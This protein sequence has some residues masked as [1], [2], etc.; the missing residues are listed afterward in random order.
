MRGAPGSDG[1]AP[2]HPVRAR[3][4]RGGRVG[5]AGLKM[6]AVMEMPAVLEMPAVTAVPA[7]PQHARGREATG[8]G[9]S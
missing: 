7:V 4:N 6:P 1:I 2:P 3:G 5:E 8:A 9:V